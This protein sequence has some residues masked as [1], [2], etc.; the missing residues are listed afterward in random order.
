MQNTD[1]PFSNTNATSSYQARMDVW[2]ATMLTRIGGM[3]TRDEQQSL[4]LTVCSYSLLYDTDTPF[5]NT[6][7]TYSCQ[8][9]MAK[10]Q[11]WR[12]TDAR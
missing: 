5:S 6:N 2:P 3:L 4:S 8:A 11:A 7:A 12:H 10:D 1:I 9:R